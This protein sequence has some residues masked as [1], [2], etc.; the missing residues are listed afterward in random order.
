MTEFSVERWGGG[1]AVFNPDGKRVSGK[2]NTQDL[3]DRAVVYARK[4]AAKTTRAC[5][6]C[7]EKF[8][9]EGRFNRLCNHCRT[10]THMP[11]LSTG[12]VF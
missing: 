11:D 8:Q 6:C 10:D 5:L 9:A 7:G 1:Y 12:C 3:A 4:R 2:H